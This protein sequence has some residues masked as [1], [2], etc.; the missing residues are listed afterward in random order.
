MFYFT[1]C[2]KRDTRRFELDTAEHKLL[3]I[4]KQSPRYYETAI[5]GRFELI[6]SDREFR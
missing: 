3:G 2:L 1:L 4:T 5:Y 6:K